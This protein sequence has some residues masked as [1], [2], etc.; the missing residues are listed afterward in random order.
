MVY[1]DPSGYNKIPDCVKT[2]NGETEDT[3]IGKDAHAELK[4]WR[5]K[6]GE[7]DYVNQKL[8]DADGN[9]ILV[10][11]RVSRK[12]GY[13]DKKMQGVIPDAIKGPEKGLFRGNG[14]C[15]PPTTP[16]FMLIRRFSI[17]GWEAEPSNPSIQDT[18]YPAYFV[19]F[20]SRMPCG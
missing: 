11:C 13:A 2:K 14:G 10:P 16:V 4:E 7:F 6:S 9:V 8:K 1:Y 12:T 17:F 19:Y 15:F 20:G 18:P 5:E 3:I